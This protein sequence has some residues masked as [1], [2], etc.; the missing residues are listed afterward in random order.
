MHYL[1]CFVCIYKI[2]IREWSKKFSNER[3]S[4]STAFNRTMLDILRNMLLPIIPYWPVGIGFVSS[5]HSLCSINYLLQHPWVEYGCWYHRNLI[6]F[7][8][9]YS[10]FL[11]RQQTERLNDDFLITLKTLLPVIYNAYAKNAQLKLLVY[12]SK[13]SYFHVEVGNFSDHLV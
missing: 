4:S 12:I 7:C 3:S 2:Y 8:G 1:V 10:L 11:I 9:W 13:C 6:Y 5:Y